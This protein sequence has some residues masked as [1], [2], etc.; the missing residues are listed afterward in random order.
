MFISHASE[1]KEA[2]ARPLRDLLT[3]RGLRVWLDE[4]QLTAGDSLRGEIDKALAGSRYGVVIFSPSFFG[5]RWPRL[6]LDALATLEERGRKVILPIW[7][8]VNHADV[9]R[10]SP[11]LADRVA[12]TTDGGLEKVADELTRAISLRRAG[13]NLSRKGRAPT[14][15]RVL[16][17][18]D[19]ED[20]RNDVAKLV[21][22]H[23]MF[24]QTASDGV[25]ALELLRVGRFDVLVTDLMMPRMDGFELLV[26]LRTMTRPPVAVVLSGSVSSGSTMVQLHDLGAFWYLE[27]PANPEAI[28]AIVDRAAAFARVRSIRRA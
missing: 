7:H 5:K 11:L 27:K 10:W 18:E 21:Q 12:V 28:R 19:E 20:E 9:M 13:F 25:E 14:P 3:I 15:P 4:E 24:V 26:E 1:D 22:D 6:E 16:V 8:K 23:G 2:V 17:V